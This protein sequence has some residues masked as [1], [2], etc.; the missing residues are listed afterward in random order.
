MPLGHRWVRRLAKWLVVAVV[1]LA[2]LNAPI[3]PR[4]TTVY[5]SGTIQTVSNTVQY[6]TAFQVYTT[7]SSSQISVYTGSYLYLSNYSS[8]YYYYCS[9]CCY[10]YNQIPICNYLYWP[11]YEP[12]R[13]STVTISAAQ[14]VVGVTKTPQPGGLE[15][16]TLTYYNGQSTTIPNVY[17]DD[18]TQNGTMTI[19]SSTVT[20]NTVVNTITTP[21]T[22]TIPC[23]QCV[24]EQV[25][26][27][28]SILQLLLGY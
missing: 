27:Y 19:R 16:L 9:Y 5:V 10:W 17:Q 3:I 23:N 8:G 1:A 24:P 14:Q 28:V 25:T 26:V 21:V 2:L 18:L 11:W 6:S 12:K 20:T 22:L 4:S 7:A 13:E 15:T